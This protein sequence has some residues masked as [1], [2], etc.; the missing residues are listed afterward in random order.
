MTPCSGGDLDWVAVPLTS[1]T[2]TSRSLA[3]TIMLPLPEKLT[4]DS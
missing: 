1:Q 3:A 2:T 4:E